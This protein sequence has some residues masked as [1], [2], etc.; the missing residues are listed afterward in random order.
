MKIYSREEAELQKDKIF[1]DILTGKL[2]IHPTDTI[3][4]LGCNA[5]NEKAVQ[6]LRN[7]KRNTSRPFSILV[8][9][10]EWI[11]ENCV[12]TPEAREWLEKLPG[13]YTLIL[14]LKNKN[15]IA[16][17]VNLGS[18]TIGVRIPDHWFAGMIKE[19][20]TPIITTSA[21]ITGSNFMT[22]ADDL[23]GM[24]AMRCAFMIDIGPIKGR[25]STIVNLA[26][27]VLSIRER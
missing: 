8:P 27:D 15:A 13:S 19:M 7:T 6:E 5:M 12:I 26:S 25:P 2:F 17:G 9:S 1:R 11:S 14:N 18:G 20:D 3:Y 21:N 16:R 22:S 4:G 10:K 24:L 23:D